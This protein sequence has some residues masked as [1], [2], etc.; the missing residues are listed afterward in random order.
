MFFRECERI[1]KPGGILVI[2]DFVPIKYFGKWMDS[3]EQ[4]LH[5][6]GRMYGEIHADISISQ[7]RALARTGGLESMSIEDITVNTLPTYRFLKSYLNRT[8]QNNAYYLAT[9]MLELV[10]K[11]RLVRYLIL[12]FRKPDRR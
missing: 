7:Y 12:A 5:L 9:F 10:S 2:S 8:G 1:L 4:A 6:V 11:M 3:F